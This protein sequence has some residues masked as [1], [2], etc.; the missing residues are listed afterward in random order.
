MELELKRGPGTLDIPPQPSRI[1]TSLSLK[2]LMSVQAAI[3]RQNL[4]PSSI[5]L[6]LREKK[7]C[8]SN[9]KGAVA[10]IALCPANT[11]Y[12]VWERKNSIFYCWWEMLEQHDPTYTCLSCCL[13]TECSLWLL[14]PPTCYPPETSSRP[15]LSTP[16][17]AKVWSYPPARHNPAIKSPVWILIWF[18][19]YMINKLMN[20]EHICMNRQK[21]RHT[22]TA[23]QREGLTAV[24]YHWANSFH[25]SA[26]WFLSILKRDLRGAWCYSFR[27]G[28]HLDS[29]VVF[30]IFLCQPWEVFFF[31][32]HTAFVFE[33]CCE[34]YMI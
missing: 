26:K 14:P 25:R 9:Y 31:L 30:F 34:N 2:R 19:S 11:S 21:K 16:G 23:Q 18:F 8:N 7:V 28:W 29:E 20:C 13:A 22:A 10:E 12:R 32:L 24:N 5:Y 17:E 3:V 33:L 27:H 6:Q 4:P 1:L 15:L